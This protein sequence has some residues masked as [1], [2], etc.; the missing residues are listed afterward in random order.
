M[1]R[2]QLLQGFAQAIIAAFLPKQAV[3]EAWRHLSSGALIENVTGIE[4]V[5]NSFIESSVF[6]TDMLAIGYGFHIYGAPTGFEPAISNT[7]KPSQ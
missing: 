3:T 4:V 6:Q 2:R 1:R 5:E 7:T